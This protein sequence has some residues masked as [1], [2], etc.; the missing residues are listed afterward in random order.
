M[1]GN[2][3]GIVSFSPGLR[4]TS[5]PGCERGMDHNPEGVASTATRKRHNPFRVGS[6]FADLPRVAPKVFGATAGLKAAS[7]LGLLNELSWILQ[8]A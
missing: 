1:S 8:E 2:P 7:P 6:Y 4:G 3:K 5:Y